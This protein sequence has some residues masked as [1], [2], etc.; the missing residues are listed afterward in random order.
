MGTG[1]G[2]DEVQARLLGRRASGDGVG[3]ALSRNNSDLLSVSPGS[4]GISSL[5]SADKHVSK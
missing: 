1:R 4:V 5:A 2:V 3:V